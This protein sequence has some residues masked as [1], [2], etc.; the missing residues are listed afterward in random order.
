MRVNQNKLGASER[1]ARN[2][3]YSLVIASVTLVGA[4]LIGA[5]R[6]SYDALL[7]L[8]IKAGIRENLAWIWP[9][10]VDGS[11]VVFS[12]AFFLGKIFDEPF[13]KQALCLVLGFGLLTVFFN[14]MHSSELAPTL[15]K[16]PA[17]VVPL[18]VWTLPPIL[19]AVN[20]EMISK[21]CE[22][23]LVNVIGIRDYQDAR[24]R[25]RE[26]LQQAKRIER[27]RRMT[28]SEKLNLMRETVLHEGVQDKSALATLLGVDRRTVDRY[29]KE[30]GLG[31][32]LALAS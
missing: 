29:W 5:F 27:N 14:A 16:I 1:F 24:K 25:E 21:I 10:L 15:A 22:S 17:W 13:K 12:I 9:G 4:V 2:L 6:L 20:T 31:D 11:L 28:K 32:K 18:M 3:K 7:D 26:A 19:V 30:L 8:A 23:V